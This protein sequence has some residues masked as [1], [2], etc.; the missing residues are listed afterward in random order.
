VVD[1]REPISQRARRW[2]VVAVLVVAAIA[3]VW[4][5]QRRNS[6][7]SNAECSARYKVARTAADTAEVDRARPSIGGRDQA[8]PLTCGQLRNPR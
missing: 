1:L 2:I 3:V 7:V 5:M 4:A 6:T 8:E